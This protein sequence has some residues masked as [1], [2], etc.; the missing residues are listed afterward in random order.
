MGISKIRANGLTMGPASTVSYSEA[1]GGSNVNPEQLGFAIFDGSSF[2][3]SNGFITLSTTGP[4]ALA[5]DKANSA[6]VLAQ[7]AF[8]KAN[9]ANVFAQASFNQANNR[10]T[11]ITNVDANTITTGQL[12]S[13]IFDQTYFTAENGFITANQRSFVTVVTGQ[14]LPSVN[15]GPPTNA[16]SAVR[17]SDLIALPADLLITAIGSLDIQM[18]AGNAYTGAVDQAGTPTYISSASNL[19]LV[20]NASS[21][22]TN[23]TVGNS[24]YN[25][26]AGTG[27][28]AVIALTIDL[29]AACNLE[30]SKYESNGTTIRNRWKGNF[31]FNAFSAL[32]KLYEINFWDYPHFDANKVNQT[33]AYQ[34]DMI[35]ISTD[36]E[37][38]SYGK[39][40]VNVSIFAAQPYHNA[41]IGARWMGTATK[42]RN[43]FASLTVLP[44]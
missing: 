44:D 43:L 10:A 28:Q 19:T 18:T 15:I 13:A 17:L 33:F 9:A 42:V 4:T 40:R 12:G 35:P 32:F 34:C 2:T 25:A 38:A 36:P 7:A 31:N 11:T 41:N 24:V 39:Y 8:N 30:S 20:G 29:A 23:Y 16:N 37:N 6:N 22:G 3:A 21:L 26:S 27:V 1:Q 5:F 14:P